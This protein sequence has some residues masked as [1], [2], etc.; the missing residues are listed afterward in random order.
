MLVTSVELFIF[1]I[2][3]ILRSQR[4]LTWRVAAV[5]ANGC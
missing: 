3:A 1:F 5:G 4:W 2:A